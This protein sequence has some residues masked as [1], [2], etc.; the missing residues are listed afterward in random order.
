[1]C[2]CVWMR[3]CTHQTQLAC[4]SYQHTRHHLNSLHVTSTNMHLTS[5]RLASLLSSPH[6]TSHHVC[7]HHYTSVFKQSDSSRTALCVHAISCAPCFR[8]HITLIKEATDRFCASFCSLCSLLHS[9]RCAPSLS[10]CAHVCLH[11]HSLFR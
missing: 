5:P 9:V 1:M 11:P 3:I 2:V 4:A 7:L 10:S 6:L 8:Q